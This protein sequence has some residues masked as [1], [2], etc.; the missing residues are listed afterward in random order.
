MGI[1]VRGTGLRHIRHVRLD[2]RGITGPA[3]AFWV[4]GSMAYEVDRVLVHE[5]FCDAE[6]CVRNH[7]VHKPAAYQLD[8][9]SEALV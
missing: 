5:L 6:R 1:D 8:M 9:G 3:L 7:S 2:G 4:V